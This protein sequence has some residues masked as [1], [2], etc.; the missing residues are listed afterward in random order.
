MDAQHTIQE[1]LDRI[2]QLEKLNLWM[3]ESFEKISTMDDERSLSGSDEGY[4]SVFN[5]AHERLTSLTEFSA[6]CFLLVN[7]AEHDFKISSIL[8]AANDADV[9]S[10][11]DSSIRDGFFGWALRQNRPVIVPTHSEQHYAVMYGL[12][13]RTK[14][15]GMFVGIIDDIA[16]LPNEVELNLVSVILLKTA[17]GIAQVELYR[18]AM[19]QNISLE[20]LV[21]QRTIELNA[22]LKEQ[23]KNE[24][25]KQTLYMISEAVHS[26]EKL[27]TLYSSIHQGLQKII[28]ANNFYI[29][30]ADTENGLI[31]FPYGV[32]ELT[33]DLYEP[34]RLNDRQSLTVEVFTTKQPLL[35]NESVLQERYSSGRNRVWNNAPKCWIGVP[36]MM[37]DRSIGVLVLQDYHDSDAY[38]MNE[39]ILLESIARQVALAIERKRVEKELTLFNWEL[40]QSKSLAEEQ[41]ENLSIKA[42]ELRKANESVEAASKLKSEFVANMS[43][44]IRTPLNGIMGLTELLLQSSLD[45]EQEKSLRL[46]QSSSNSLLTIIND[47]LDFSKIE[48]GKLSIEQIEFDLREVINDTLALLQNRMIAKGLLLDLKLD[49]GNEMM[50]IGDPTRLRQV[51]TNLTGNAIKFT[52]RGSVSITIRREEVNSESSIIHVAITDTGIGIPEHVINNLFQSFSQAD[53]STTRKYGGTGLGLAISKRLIELMGGTIGVESTA[54]KGS[55]FWFTL[56]FLN[57]KKKNS[58]AS[59]NAASVTTESVINDEF[60]KGLVKILIAEDNYINQKVCIGMLAKLGY[61]ATMVGNGLEALNEFERQP[62]DIILMDCQMP[63]MD[64]FEATIRIRQNEKNGAHIPIIA[65]TANAFQSDKDKCRAAGMDGHLSKPFNQRELGEVLKEWC[66][67]KHENGTVAVSA[68]TA[69]AENLINQAMIENNIDS[70]DLGTNELLKMMESFLSEDVPEKIST[71]LQAF[72][73]NDAG[74]MRHAAHSL[75]GSSSQLGASGLSELC[76]TME[77]N[78]LANDLSSIPAMAVE[79]ESIVVSTRMQVREYLTRRGE[80]IAAAALID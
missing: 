27:E 59:V 71:L 9:R 3:F 18:K 13:T 43:H 12:R 19:I 57:G 34:V 67:S 36:L 64:G 39:V 16:S 63:E 5:S 15:V 51:V 53:G 75:R 35:L 24:K 47:I 30:I 37:K 66:G 44:E 72:S 14:V 22:A 69:T 28:P 60:D 52:D 46:I 80:E 2:S 1:M 49:L 40:I 54:G 56:T 38:G 70:L 73:A 58:E 45:Q 31:N 33:D 77:I 23:Q 42:E 62:Y 20:Q 26:A 55:T 74:E 17:I 8:P 7:E 78:I 21:E 11:V 76:K 25:T 68:E 65:M 41:A 10:F 50:F 4:S 48:A 6:T 29:A 79:L 32:D 61:S